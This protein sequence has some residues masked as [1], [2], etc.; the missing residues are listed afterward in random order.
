MVVR[1]SGFAKHVAITLWVC[2]FG[3]NPKEDKGNIRMKMMVIQTF[4]CD[5]S[6]GQM[7]ANQQ[8]HK[9][10]EHDCQLHKEVV[11]CWLFDYG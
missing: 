9:G 10:I 3:I 5:V 11:I 4:S 6:A 8:T 2:F 7:P 1:G